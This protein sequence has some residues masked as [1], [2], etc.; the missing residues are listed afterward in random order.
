LELI[1]S[2]NFLL[3]RL[4]VVGRYRLRG[5][6][7]NWIGSQVVADPPFDNSSLGNLFSGDF[8]EWHVGGELSFP[9]GFRRAHAA[10]RHAQLQQAR[11]TAL[12]QE[13]ERRVLHDLS[14]AKAD[15]DRAYTTCRTNYSR[16][17]AAREQ[18]RI[19]RRKREQDMRINLD[20]WIDAQRRLADADSQFHRSCAEYMIAIKN[21]H[22]E[23]GSLLEYSQVHLAGAA[24]AG[25]DCGSGQCGPFQA[26]SRNL[27][28]YVLR[29]GQ[30]EDT[31]AGEGTTSESEL[32]VPDDV[33]APEHEVPPVDLAPPLST[34]APHDR[35][36][37]F[38]EAQ[39][40]AHWF[41]SEPPG[42]Q[43]DNDTSDWSGAQ[44][45]VPNDPMP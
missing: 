7:K 23:K 41:P 42:L 24:V 11:A 44:W 9:I 3:P 37:S 29:R 2:R 31:E 4:D 35:S 13:Q 12:L 43:L 39:A 14:N 10:V 27:M 21:F 45:P 16:L 8:Q 22:F 18:L 19:L 34:P 20:Q 26:A 6:G 17:L 36:A 1:A 32:P 5:L 40:A 25:A 15:M 38:H 30:P 28:D 33:S